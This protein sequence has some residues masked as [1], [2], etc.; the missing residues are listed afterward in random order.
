M[1]D[2]TRMKFSHVQPTDGK[3]GDDRLRSFFCCRN[4]GIIKEA[5]H[6]GVAAQIVT[7]S[8][9]PQDGTGWRRHEA[10]FHNRL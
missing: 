9:A 4:L 7:A 6:S 1:L 5:S 10:D 8:K 3:I 2:S